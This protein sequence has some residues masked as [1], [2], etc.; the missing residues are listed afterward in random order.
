MS[1]IERMLFSY[2]AMNQ[3][4]K[5]FPLEKSNETYIYRRYNIYLF[6]ISKFRRF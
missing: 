3:D 4:K 6:Y 5:T 2:N 1:K